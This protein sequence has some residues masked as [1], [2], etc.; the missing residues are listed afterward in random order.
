[1]E[2][3]LSFVFKRI[4]GLWSSWSYCKRKARY[5][6]QPLAN[7]VGCVSGSSLSYKYPYHAG[8]EDE[9]MRKLWK[10]HFSEVINPYDCI[11]SSVN[12]LELGQQALLVPLNQAS[13]RSLFVSARTPFR[14]QRTARLICRRRCSSLRTSTRSLPTRCAA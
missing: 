8:F 3:L 6:E 5:F 13:S 2:Y 10:H 14:F 4:S 9:R 1:M 11:I 12:W 7:E